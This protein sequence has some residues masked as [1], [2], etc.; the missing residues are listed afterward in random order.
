MPNLN[1][2]NAYIA[3]KLS[4][5]VYTVGG[6]TSARRNPTG[7]IPGNQAIEQEANA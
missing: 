2:Y 3:I 1:S 5:L 7:T 6:Q 4:N